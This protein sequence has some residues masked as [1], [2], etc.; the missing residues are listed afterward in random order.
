MCVIS[1]RTN[2]PLVISRGIGARQK[3][4][5]EHVPRCLVAA[6]PS[7]R[8]VAA[9]EAALRRHGVTQVCVHFSIIII[10]IIIIILIILIIIL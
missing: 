7:G 8:E 5:C 3:P 6:T 10:I 9:D 2:A 4:P 1:R